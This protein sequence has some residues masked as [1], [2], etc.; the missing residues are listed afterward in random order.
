MGSALT[1]AYAR[2]YGAALL[3]FALAP[4][5][6]ADAFGAEVEEG[7]DMPPPAMAPGMDGMDAPALPQDL[8]AP[9]GD[10]VGGMPTKDAALGLKDM[11][12]FENALGKDEAHSLFHGIERSMSGQTRGTPQTLTFG[13]EGMQRMPHPAGAP[14]TRPAIPA[15]S[16]GRASMPP[17]IASAPPPIPAAAMRPRM[18]GQ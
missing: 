9:V 17:P 6:P 1:Q 13:P 15:P 10:P 3:K 18:L 16:A 8:G 2:G 5:T 11:L 12:F 14:A 7:K 4:P